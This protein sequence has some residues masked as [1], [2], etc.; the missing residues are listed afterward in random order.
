MTIVILFLSL[1]LHRFGG[2]LERYGNHINRPAP[3]VARR[4]GVGPY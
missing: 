4:V 2:N 3:P 1:T